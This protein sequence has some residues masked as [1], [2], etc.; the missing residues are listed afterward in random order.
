[1]AEFP[2]RQHVFGDPSIWGA[3]DTATTATADLAHEPDVR[4]REL[5]YSNKA[6]TDHELHEAWKQDVFQ[7]HQDIFPVRYGDSFYRNL[8]K[9]NFKTVVAIDY[10]EV[11]RCSCL[12]LGFTFDLYLTACFCLLTGTG[13]SN[14]GW[15]CHRTKSNSPVSY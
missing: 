9:W 15:C 3:E 13:T 8:K 10:S 6:V 12:P 4:I 11:R 14:C 7:I 2:Q 5:D 1:M